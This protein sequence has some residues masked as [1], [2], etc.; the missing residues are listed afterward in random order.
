MDDLASRSGE[1]SSEPA[2][3]REAGEITAEMEFVAIREALVHGSLHWPGDPHDPRV[4]IRNAPVPIGTVPS[5]QALEKVDGS[6]EDL[7]SVVYRD[8]IIEQC[9]QGVDYVTV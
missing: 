3:Q 4:V 2:S 6:A 5:Y 1:S 7:S 8:T 9:E